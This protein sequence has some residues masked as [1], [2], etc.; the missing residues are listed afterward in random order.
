MAA[1]LTDLSGK[2]VKY[3]AAE[4]PAFEQG[5]KARGLPE[6][7]VGRIIGF[8]TDIKNGQEDEIS[9]D[10]EHLLGRQPATLH[11]GLKELYQL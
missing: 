11:A 7:V 8:L 4:V 5:L 2:S 10:L 3:T 9:S 1:A 6:V